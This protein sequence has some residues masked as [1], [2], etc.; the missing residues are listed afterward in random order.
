MVAPLGFFYLEFCHYA[1]YISASLEARL[2]SVALG[3]R[4]QLIIKEN[5]KRCT[6]GEKE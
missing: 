3:K 5:K 1:N 2:F 4:Y 6:F